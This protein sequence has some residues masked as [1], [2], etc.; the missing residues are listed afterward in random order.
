L[1]MRHI[2]LSLLVVIAGTST[3]H[4]ADTAADSLKLLISVEQTTLTAPYP[5]R[6]TLHIYN[7]GKA[8]V[9]L[10]RRARG[11]TR[12]GSSLE[13]RLE[14][15]RPPGSPELS[16]PAAGRVLESV[17]LPRPRLVRLAP[18]DDYTEKTTLKIAPARTGKNGEGSPLWGRYRLAVGYRAAFPNAPEITRTLAVELWQ[19]EVKSNSIEIELQPPVAEGSV[20]GSVRN[21]EGHGVSGA[22]VSLVDQEDRLVDQLLADVEGRFS[23]THLPLGADYWVT[24][25]RPEASEDTTV[26]RHLSLTPAAPAGTIELVLL[27]KEIHQ[28]QYLLH[29]PVLFRVTDSAGRPLDKVSLEVIWSSG[30]VL[31][32]VKGATLEDGTV[33][34]ELIPGRNFV[35]LR[36]RGCP[37][38][39][40]RVDVTPGSGIDS[41]KLILECAKK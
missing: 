2:A 34:L 29:K 30:T 12:E 38:Q 18:G 8:P 11:E 15:I 21:A 22:L 16:A 26:F 5:A 4:P 27:P 3:A 20:A 33:A 37:K 41:F 25:R 10:Y 19:G 40:Q 32:Q 31:E 14:P 28:P 7:S 39:E 9:W 23:F 35:T 17:G 6:L 36:R 24:V 1:R 13:A